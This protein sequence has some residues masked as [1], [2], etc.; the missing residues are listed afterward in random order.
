MC[1]KFTCL[2]MV[3]FL[4]I[5]LISTVSATP[6]LHAEQSTYD[7]GE[8]FQGDKVVHTFSFANA[9]DEPLLIDRV[10]SSCGCT[11][12]LLSSK[13]LAPGETGT[14]KAT[15]DSSRFRGRV[16]KVIYLY[17]NLPNKTSGRFMLQGEVKPL[18]GYSP[19][20]L[21]FGSVKVGQE[22]KLPLVLTNATNNSLKI[23]NIRA[24][25]IALG[26]TTG[27]KN[28]PPGEDV[29]F[30]AYARPNEETRHLNGYL[31]IRTDD[32]SLGEIRVP[33][34]GLVER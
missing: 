24:N 1:H 10:K 7:F 19:L 14:I 23:E 30:E 21:E 17:G 26:A 20:T 16:Q 6:V 5:A 11:A 3:L 8:V 32:K 4:S 18:V 22:K 2:L 31:L 29:S 34:R 28:L 12:A 25:N 13:K 33:V 27:A 9:G 15:F